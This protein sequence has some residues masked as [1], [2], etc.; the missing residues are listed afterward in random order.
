MARQRHGSDVRRAALRRYD[1][2]TSEDVAVSH[3]QVEIAHDLGVSVATVQRWIRD[4]RNQEEREQLLHDV[5]ASTSPMPA[6]DHVAD[7]TPLGRAQREAAYRHFGGQL[8]QFH[9]LAL[10]KQTDFAERHSEDPESYLEAT[11]Q[12]AAVTT[13]AVSDAVKVLVMLGISN[14]IPANRLANWSN[15]APATVRLWEQEGERAVDQ[16]K[17]AGGSDPTAQ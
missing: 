8:A 17:S 14:D 16:Y 13:Q 9:A 5:S 12:L 1:E 15:I 11:L 2:L 3:A 10:R 6:W 7:D 4:R